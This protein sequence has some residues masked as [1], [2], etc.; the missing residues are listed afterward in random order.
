M[1]I[2]IA[3]ANGGISPGEERACRLCGVLSEIESAYKIFGD[4]QN[5]YAAT[6]YRETAKEK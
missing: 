4:C 2:Y 3:F 6:I 1:C 5:L